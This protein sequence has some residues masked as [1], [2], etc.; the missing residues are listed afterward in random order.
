MNVKLISH[1]KDP[2][3]V[4]A[5]AAKLCYSKVGIEDILEKQTE[6]SASK[7][8]SKLSN[9]GHA[10]P[11]EHASFTFGIDGVSRAFLAQITRHRIA[12]FSVQSQR[13][14]KL[15]DFNYVTPP[16]IYRDP[17]AYQM[18][19]SSMSQQARKYLEIAATLEEKY[20][21]EAIVDGLPE[22]QAKSV[23]EKRA[24][25]DARYALPNACETKMVVTM[26]AR[27]L[28]HFFN[29]RCCMRA[30]WEIRRVADEMLKLVHPIAPNLF[31]N[32]GPS[33]VAFGYCPESGMS[34]G[35]QFE[36]IEKYENIK[37]I[38]N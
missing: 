23:A 34:C 38:S 6:E 24:I 5:A 26:N 31:K 37:R 30:Q 16:E 25:E 33:C 10:S 12:S 22:K 18:F 11:T 15:D 27:E 36:I 28:N 1:T 20:Y 4:V 2:E 19:V 21:K 29:L 7:F 35:R 17:E 32:A 13:Y 14:V 9:L 8:L 3:Q